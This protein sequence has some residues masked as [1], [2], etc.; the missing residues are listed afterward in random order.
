MPVQ[1]VVRVCAGEI[2][3]VC[4]TGDQGRYPLLLGVCEAAQGCAQADAGDLLDG[5]HGFG[6]LA[7]RVERVADHHIRHHEQGRD[8]ISD[9][10]KV[11][12]RVVFVYF[13]QDV[14]FQ[15]G[16]L[17]HDVRDFV[18]DRKALAGRVVLSGQ[19]DDGRRPGVGAVALPGDDADAEG[20]AEAFRVGGPLGALVLFQGELN[21]GVRGV[22]Q[23]S[24]SQAPRQ[25]G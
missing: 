8:V 13:G 2:R 24:C 14:V 6:M 11:A 20:P 21:G 12:L 3:D 25:P 15:S 19:G 16:A 9:G 18:V 1:P 17:D 4:P 5:Q 23:L 10:L 22:S 7:I